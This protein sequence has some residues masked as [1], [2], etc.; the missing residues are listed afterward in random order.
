MHDV[1]VRVLLLRE[2]ARVTARDVVEGT[3]ALHVDVG[4]QAF[5]GVQHEVPRTNTVVYL[6][7][8]VSEGTLCICLSFI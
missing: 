2:H 4:V 6:S 1:R 7:P 3:H 8:H 5:V